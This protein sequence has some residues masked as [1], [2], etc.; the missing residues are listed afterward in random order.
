M[1]V[2]PTIYCADIGSVAAGRFAWYG[3]GEQGVSRHSASMEDLAAAVAEDLVSG[4]PAALGFE[5]PLFVPLADQP[6]DLTAARSGDG[7]RPW[8]AGA[9]CGALTTGLVQVAWILSRIREQAG[10]NH[11]AFLNWSAFSRVASGLF[12]WEAFVTGTAKREGHAADAQA[13]VEAF[14]AAIQASGPESAVSCSGQVYSLVG[15]A[16]LRTGW[17]TDISLLSCPCVV[18]RAT[19]RAV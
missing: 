5:C 10:E 12:L 14:N 15:A 6:T 19:A 7:N 17:S 16:L 11:R 2:Q 4:V 18:I 1:G 3:N 13:A 9:G 8:S